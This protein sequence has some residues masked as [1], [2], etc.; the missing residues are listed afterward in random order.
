M[1]DFRPPHRLHILLTAPAYPTRALAKG[2]VQLAVRAQA[3]RLARRHEVTVVAPYR[4]YPPLARY[5]RKR[6]EVPPGPPDETETPADVTAAENAVERGTFRED[7]YFRLD[8]IKLHM[9]A[10]KDRLDEIEP[11][12]HQFNAEFARVHGASQLQF[13]HDAIHQFMRH[14]WPG[15]IRELRAVIERLHVLCGSDRRVI[16]ADDVH[17]FGQLP[18]FNQVRHPVLTAPCLASLKLDA[19]DQTLQAC[20]G[21]VSRAAS[22][23]GVHR[24]TLYR[25]LAERTA[26]AA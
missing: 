3:E 17:H 14:S 11:L 16:D 20:R 19:V 2:G 5:A 12:L 7:L 13:T 1:D 26:S 21:N 23:L 10:L 4:V 15:N 22:A 25:W 24:S 9:Q 8:V 18:R 6:R